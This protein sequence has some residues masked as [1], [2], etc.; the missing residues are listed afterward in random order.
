LL[1]GANFLSTSHL[2]ALG[3]GFSQERAAQMRLKRLHDAGY[4]DH[5]RPVSAYGRVEWNYRLTSL[6]FSALRLRECEMVPDERRYTPAPLTSISYV[7]HDLQLASIVLHIAQEAAVDGQDAPIAQM[8]FR[9]LGPRNGHIEIDGDGETE[10]SPAAQLLPG[11][12]LFPAGSRTGYL[13]PDATLI[14]GSGE[15]LFAVLIE[16]DRTDRPHK[17]IDRLRRYDRWLLDGWRKG[18]FAAHAIPPA[19]IFLTS[20]EGPLSRLIE[21][22]DETF[23]ASYGGEHTH[24]SE[25]TYPA[26]E[27]VLFA[28]R[29]QVLAGDWAMRRAPSLPA[30]LREE[31]GVC[32]PRVIE[33]D[34]SSLFA[35]AARL[36][37]SSG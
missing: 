31:P 25:D 32:E 10:R 2:T 29:E 21:T 27:R 17:Q 35:E 30:A 36:A 4:V 22:A 26:R 6:G 16:Y 5:F 24:P 23:F 28:S 8:P 18:P 19:V 3:W 15:D 1:Y 12:H 11:T 13:E 14:G 37:A 7:E 9:W 33:Y 20:R 34:L